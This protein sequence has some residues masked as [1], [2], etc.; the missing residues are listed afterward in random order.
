MYDFKLNAKF[1]K[2]IHTVANSLFYAAFFPI[3][4]VITLIGLG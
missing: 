2:I 4:M 1:G 3:G